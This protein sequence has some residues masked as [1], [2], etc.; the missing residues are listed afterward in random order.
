MLVVVTEGPRRPRWSAYRFR[1]GRIYL[2]DLEER[3]GN[4]VCGHTRI[5]ADP[6][7]DRE[8]KAYSVNC[9]F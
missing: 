4:G 8:S 9:G 3:V 7:A 1:R 2:L 5:L 6:P